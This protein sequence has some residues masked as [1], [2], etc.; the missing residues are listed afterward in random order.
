M[1]GIEAIRGEAK[2]LEQGMANTMNPGSTD[3]AED[4]MIV[5]TTQ[6]EEE[7]IGSLTAEM[8]EGAALTKIV[9][10]EVT[11]IEEI[12]MTALEGMKT[13]QIVQDVFKMEKIARREDSIVM[14]VREKRGLERP[15]F[16]MGTM[17]SERQEQGMIK[18]IIT[19]EGLFGLS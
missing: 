14:T 11:M 15:L 1:I 4:S 5:T 7:M 12:M 18:R 8:K 6:R 17:S 10:E 16:H 19:K 9:R 2:A 13:E 3:R